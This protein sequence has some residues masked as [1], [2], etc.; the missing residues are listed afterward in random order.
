MQWQGNGCA[1]RMPISSECP[2]STL[3]YGT[4]EYQ[5]HNKVSILLQE[6]AWHKM[7]FYGPCSQETINLEELEE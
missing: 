7:G 6:D 2:D 3:A 1:G 4:S 5:G